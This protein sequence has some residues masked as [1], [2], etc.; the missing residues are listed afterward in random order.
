VRAL[1]FG[2]GLA[3]AGPATACTAFHAV[4][5]G[6]HVVGKS[7][8]WHTGEALVVINPRGV[9][10]TAFLGHL[11]DEPA[12]WVS[13]YGSVT[14]DQYG[15]EMPSGGINEAGLVVEV[16]VRYPEQLACT[17]TDP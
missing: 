13:R 11:A 10:K 17:E 14:F 16:L 9:A 5:G 4:R 12:S 8:D 7:Y 15:P 1:V 2:I 3:L 6:Q